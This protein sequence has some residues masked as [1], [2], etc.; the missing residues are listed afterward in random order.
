MMRAGLFVVSI[1]RCAAIPG[2]DMEFPTEAAEE[3]AST[4]LYRDAV[5]VMNS[6]RTA[7][8][9]GELGACNGVAFSTWTSVGPEG[10]F[11]GSESRV[12]VG[13]AGA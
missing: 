6:L 9:A 12:L 2:D 5:A 13:L 11:V 4:A 1:T 10:G 7:E 8:K 3:V